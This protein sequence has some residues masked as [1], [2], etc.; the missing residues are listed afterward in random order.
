VSLNLT[1]TASTSFDEGDLIAT[2]GTYEMYALE[3]K[4]I[5]GTGTLLCLVGRRSVVTTAVAG[6]AAFQAFDYTVDDRYFAQQ[7]EAF[8]VDGDA[9]P[10]QSDVDYLAGVLNDFVL[11]R[12][13]PSHARIYTENNI[14]KYIKKNTSKLKYTF[15]TYNTNITAALQARPRMLVNATSNGFTVTLSPAFNPDKEDVRSIARFYP[16]DGRIVQDNDYTAIILKNFGG[17]LLD[18][19]SF[20]D[21]PIQKIS[22]IKDDSFGSGDQAAEYIAAIKNLV[23]SKRAKGM[24]VSYTYKAKSVGLTFTAPMTVPT[25]SYTN[26]LVEAANDYLEGQLYKFAREE[27]TITSQSVAIDLSAKFGVPFTPTTSVSL[28]MGVQDFLKAISVTVTA[29]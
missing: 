27:K 10:L 12:V 2:L 13:M 14:I 19:Y 6:L 25:L 16:F 23:D 22:L 11:R 17:I 15:I 21:D 8:T 29:A 28:A 26:A 20:N 24:R 1:T 18:V 3:S 4:T 5:N 7:L 9:V